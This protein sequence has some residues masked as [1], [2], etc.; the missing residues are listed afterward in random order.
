MDVRITS[1]VAV[2]IILNFHCTEFIVDDRFPPHC[3]RTGWS[4][5]PIPLYEAGEEYMRG[6]FN[7]EEWSPTYAQFYFEA[8]NVFR[9]RYADYNDCQMV[10]GAG[11]HSIRFSTD[12]IELETAYPIPGNDF[13]FFSFYNNNHNEAHI[14]PQ[15]YDSIIVSQD[16]PSY[17]VFDEITPD[18]KY[19]KGRFQLNATKRYPFRYY[20]SE[21]WGVFIRDV[22]FRLRI[23]TR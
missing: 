19:I 15:A 4:T 17:I 9:F 7:N 8:R 21:S 14:F 23:S 11:T 6:Y 13:S 1:L 22:E 5:F 10:T 18:R 20:K 16:W 12:T 3:Q 2:L